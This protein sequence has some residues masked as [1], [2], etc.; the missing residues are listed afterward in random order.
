MIK[1]LKEHCG[2]NSKTDGESEVRKCWRNKCV[3]YQ[4]R[5]PH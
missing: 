3:L 2:W 1:E 4:A 5:M